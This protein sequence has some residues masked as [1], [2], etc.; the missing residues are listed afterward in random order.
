MDTYE[1]LQAHNKVRYV[2]NKH[3]EP[4]L[5]SR[6][7]LTSLPR[8]NISVSQNKQQLP[9]TQLSSQNFMSINPL[10]IAPVSFSEVKT[11]PY[12]RE[13]LSKRRLRSGR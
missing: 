1:A 9:H 2:W 3:L 11:V 12:E 5:K 13:F 6:Y 8:S 4:S 7:G 10:K